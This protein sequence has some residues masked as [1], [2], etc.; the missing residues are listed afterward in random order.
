MWPQIMHYLRIDFR[1]DSLKQLMIG[2]DA[3]VGCLKK[4]CDNSSWYDA[5]WLLEESEPMYGIAFVAFQNYINSSIHDHPEYESDVKIFYNTNSDQNGERKSKIELIIALANY[6]KHKDEDEL[7]KATRETLEYFDLN[8][9]KNLDLG[10]SPIFKGM[11]ILSEEWDLFE[12]LKIVEEWREELWIKYEC[13]QSS[14]K[15]S[16]KKLIT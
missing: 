10:E 2:I 4:Q 16:N 7:R 13:I 1:I 11:S 8:P 12:M 9:S 14:I 5:N 6:F 3:S 15:T